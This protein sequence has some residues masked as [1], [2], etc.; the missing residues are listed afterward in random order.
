VGE[1]V[2]PIVRAHVAK[3]VLV[4]DQSIRDAQ[5]TLWRAMRIVVEPGGAAAL[6]A[7]LSGRYRPEPGERVGIVVSGGNTVAVAFDR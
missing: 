1:L 3:V 4:T 5:E 2:F 6:A 7:L